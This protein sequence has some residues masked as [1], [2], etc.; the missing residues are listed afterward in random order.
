MDALSTL[1]CP[2]RTE[3]PKSPNICHS[4]SV[5]RLTEK[6]ATAAATQYHSTHVHVNRIRE[7][8]ELEWHNCKS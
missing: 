6:P 4:G 1:L 3:N 2:T 8:I 7:R 5:E